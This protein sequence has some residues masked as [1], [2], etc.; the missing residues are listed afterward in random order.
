MEDDEPMMPVANTLTKPALVIP[1]GALSIRALHEAISLQGE[2]SGV[3]LGSAAPVEHPEPI[4]VS[5]D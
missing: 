3:A 4:T 5:S 2:I 1:L